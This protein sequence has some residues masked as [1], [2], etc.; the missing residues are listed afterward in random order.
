MSWTF[1]CKLHQHVSI[2]KTDTFHP[3][4]EHCLAPQPSHAEGDQPDTKNGSPWNRAIGCLVPHDGC[5]SISRVQHVEGYGWDGLAPAAW[6]GCRRCCWL[7][8]SNLELGSVAKNI[9]V[10]EKP[11]TNK[12]FSPDLTVGSYMDNSASPSLP[13][14]TPWHFRLATGLRWH[15]LAWTCYVY[16]FPGDTI[17]EVWNGGEWWCWI[18]S[19]APR[20]NMYILTHGVEKYP[21]V[22]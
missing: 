8:Q 18:V 1:C 2:W 17:L 11:S 7:W 4:L 13:S 14:L 15:C 12:G 5:H 9:H 19:E 21:L 3:R 10:Q 22:N 20:K 6:V 16:I